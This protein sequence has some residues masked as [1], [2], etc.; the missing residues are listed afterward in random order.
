MWRWNGP[1]IKMVP[2]P[3]ESHLLLQLLSVEMS[4]RVKS[5]RSL[6]QMNM[7]PV[8]SEHVIITT[9]T[10]AFGLWSFIFERRALF[11]AVGGAAGN[12]PSR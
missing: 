1:V 10:N 12:P 8:Q 2:V 5:K 4:V 11:M 3:A 6:I 9:L 7:T